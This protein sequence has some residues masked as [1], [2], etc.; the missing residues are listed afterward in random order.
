MIVTNNTI[1]YTSKGRLVNIDT[2]D[3]NDYKTFKNCIISNNTVNNTDYGALHLDKVI[4]NTTVNLQITDPAFK[5]YSSVFSSLLLFGSYFYMPFTNSV[6]NYQS[7]E[8]MTVTKTGT[9]TIENNARNG[10]PC[11]R[12]NRSGYLTTKNTDLFKINIGDVFT[13]QFYFKMA[14]LSWQSVFSLGSISTDGMLFRPLI[15]SSSFFCDSK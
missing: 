4:D 12:F 13:V 15:H 7:S 8:S 1:N 14:D 2:S 9:V 6:T 5:I 10:K 11:A 3:S